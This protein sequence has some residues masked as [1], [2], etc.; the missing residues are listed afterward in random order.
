Q[1]S[2]LPKAASHGG[3]DNYVFDPL[4]ERGPMGAQPHQNVQRQL[5]I[6]GAGFYKLELRAGLR[7]GLGLLLFGKPLGEL[8]G[9]QLAEERAD[10]D[11]GI[12]VTEPTGGVSFFFI[13][14]IN[15]TIE[16]QLHEPR[17]GE[18]PTNCYLRTQYIGELV[19]RAMLN[20]DS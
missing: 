9:K 14:S 2:L 12:E 4:K 20:A 6:V 10:A 17:E 19:H 7:S 18:W 11:T 16:C 1:G 15:R 3:L 13:I 5:A 8:P